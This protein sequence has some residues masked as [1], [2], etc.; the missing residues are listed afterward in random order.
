[1]RYVLTAG[2]SRKKI[3]HLFLTCPR[4]KAFWSDLRTWLITNVNIDLPLD[5]RAVLFS[6]SGENELLNYIYVLAKLFIYKNKFI[7]IT[8][9]IQGFINFLKKKKMLS[10]KYISYINNKFNKFM[11]KWSPFYHF[12]LPSTNE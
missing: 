5:D 2:S 4:V 3:H 11:K 10:E 6:Y 1:M 12:F 7:S 9:Y 8:I